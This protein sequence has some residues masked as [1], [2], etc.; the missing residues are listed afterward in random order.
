[1]SVYQLELQININ[2][3]IS[4]NDTLRMLRGNKIQAYHPIS[5]MFILPAATASTDM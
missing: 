1:M 3:V 5:K 2:Y 4:E